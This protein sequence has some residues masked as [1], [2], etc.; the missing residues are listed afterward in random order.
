MPKTETDT[1]SRSHEIASLLESAHEQVLRSW[2]SDGASEGARIATTEPDPCVRAPRGSR[3][4]VLLGG[5]RDSTRTAAIA[6][7]QGRA[8]RRRLRVTTLLV[9]TIGAAVSC[10]IL[11]LYAGNLSRTFH[12]ILLAC[13]S[14]LL[15]SVLPTERTLI[16]I[17]CITTLLLFL[18]GGLV[19]LYSG[20]LRR[21][22]ASTRCGELDTF[23]CAF[24]ADLD[25]LPLVISSL[26]GIGG[27]LVIALRLTWLLAHRPSSRHLLDAV[28]SAFGMGTF[29]LAIRIVVLHHLA[30]A[31]EAATDADI[32]STVLILIIL[33]AICS[34]CFS[35]RLRLRLTGWLASRGAANSSASMMAQL[36]GAGSA[37]QV[38]RLSQALLRSVSFDVLR[39]SDL[40]GPMIPADARARTRPA[41]IGEIDAFVCARP[42]PRPLFTAALQ[43]PLP[44]AWGRRICCTVRSGLNACVRTSRHLCSA[45]SVD[46]LRCPNPPGEPLVASGCGG[47]VGGPLRVG[48][49]LQ[50]EVWP[51]ATPLDRQVL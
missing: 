5:S 18:F 33:A 37:K 7:V 27:C 12:A 23:Q 47:K 3:V 48:V 28:W 11:M 39:P 10:I 29:V 43:W 40:S 14:T 49:R 24:L 34:M 31:D 8:R 46:S 42:P 16:K 50:A 30:M 25:L 21:R 2:C 9:G 20:R 51:L 45:H 32:V 13:V 35:T 44:G 26:L 17:V 19:Q 41:H 4:F 22:P 1:L 15:L 6:A 38:L 36:M